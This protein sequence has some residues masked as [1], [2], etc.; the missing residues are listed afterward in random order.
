[1]RI[2]STR[3]KKI[4]KS[5]RPNSSMRTTSTKNCR[6][7]E[8]DYRNITNIDMLQIQHLLQHSSRLFDFYNYHL[9]KTTSNQ[10]PNSTD[11]A[12]RTNVRSTNQTNQLIWVKSPTQLEP[13]LY[14]PTPC[15]VRKTVAE[16]TS[17][18]RFMISNII[19]DG[20]PY[21][22]V[23]LA[24]VYESVRRSVAR[25]RRPKGGWNSR[26]PAVWSVRFPSARKVEQPTGQRALF[27]SLT[28][29]FFSLSFFSLYSSYSSPLLRL[30]FAPRNRSPGDR[31]RCVRLTSRRENV[32][33]REGCCL[34]PSCTCSMH[35]QP[36]TT[37]RIVC[38]RVRP[39][40]FLTSSHSP[41]EGEVRFCPGETVPS[42]NATDSCAVSLNNGAGYTSD[43]LRENLTGLWGYEREEFARLFRQ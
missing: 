21:S 15:A 5:R 20:D 19:H 26:R 1:M 8:E 10:T 7:S 14:L 32:L 41:S 42:S 16:S 9:F 39:R 24:N 36:G 37:L 43:E 30:G 34:H 38:T 40:N 28:T 29:F 23:K 22:S 12:K 35:T 27:I 3:R 18:T 25:V 4:E 17:L 11:D 31:P 13:L 2:I 33:P 6:K